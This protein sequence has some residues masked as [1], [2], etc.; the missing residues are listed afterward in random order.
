MIDD[1]AARSTDRGMTSGG[2]QP[3]HNLARQL[4]D[5]ARS[6]QQ[7]PGLDRTLDA[8]VHAA[9][10]NIPGAT[11]A[12]ISR[13]DRRRR[14]TTPAATDPTVRRIDEV[15]YRTGEGPCLD[16][17][18]EQLTVRV[19]DL[20]V[21]PRWPAFAGAA[22]DL[23]ILSMLAVQLYVHADDLGALNLYSADAAAFD[24]RDEQIGLLLAS[25]ASIAMIGAE[26]NQQLRAAMTHRDVIGRAEGILMERHKITAQ[27]AFGLLVHASQDRNRKLHDIA[28]E[29][30][31]T[32]VD[33]A[34]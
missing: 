14:I 9:V 3:D 2:R 19:D 17:I 30:V 32:G 15:Q 5:M 11:Y 27:Q 8:I 6:L 18:R 1:R 7:A 25:H 10:V 21:D 29:F 12:G 4:S 16:A 20:R 13:I 28:E 33:P 26:E 22:A 31:T 23:G 34:E 24:D